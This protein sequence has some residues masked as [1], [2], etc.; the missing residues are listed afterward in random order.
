[1]REV[2]ILIALLVMASVLVALVMVFL[3]AIYLVVG[4]AVLSL[5]WFVRTLRELAA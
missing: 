5:V 1:L 4:M 2:E 3:S